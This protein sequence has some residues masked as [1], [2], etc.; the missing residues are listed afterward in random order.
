[1]QQLSVL[2]LNFRMYQVLWHFSAS[3][4]LPLRECECPRVTAL[5]V[6]VTH[7]FFLGCRLMAIATLT[8][9]NARAQCCLSRPICGPFCSYFLTIMSTPSFTSQKLCGPGFP[10]SLYYTPCFFSYLPLPPPS[11]FLPLSQDISAYLPKDLPTRL[12]S[13]FL[14]LLLTIE[15]G[16]S[17]FNLGWH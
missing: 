9:L 4:H 8:L 1:M 2:R 6:L 7:T 15:L 5:H 10:P 13:F 16:W 17:V 14:F 3:L 11:V 12:T